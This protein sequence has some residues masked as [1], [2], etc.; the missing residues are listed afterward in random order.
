MKDKINGNHKP[1]IHELLK[2]VKKIVKAT[3]ERVY[4]NNITYPINVE[5]IAQDFNLPIYKKKLDDDLAGCF[6]SENGASAIIINENDIEQRQRFTISHELGHFISYKLQE[7][8]GSVFDERSKLAFLGT[9]PEEIFANK[10]AAELLM[11]IEELMDDSCKPDYKKA[12]KSALNLLNKLGYTYPPIDPIEISNALGVKVIFV[13]F[14]N[15]EEYIN[16]SGF[17]FAKENSIYVNKNESASRQIFTISHE[18]G[19]KVL[20]NEWANT[21]DYQVLYKENLEIPSQNLYEQEANCFAANLLVPRHMLNKY[22]N[23]ANVEE[24]ARLF[25]VPQSVIRNRLKD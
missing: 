25:I 16:I 21:N 17:Y 7:K 4:K 12:K 11:P 9:D 18:L 10:F 1:T 19:H 2:Y 14:D 24:L 6:V 23:F 8:T 20:H 3:V 22:K 5:K 13:N 15:F